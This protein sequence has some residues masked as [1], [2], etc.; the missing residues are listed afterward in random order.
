MSCNGL[1]DPGSLAEMNTF[2]LVWKMENEEASMDTVA[3]K[4]QMIINVTEFP[5]IPPEISHA[6]SVTGGSM[7]PLFVSAIGEASGD[8]AFFHDYLQGIHRRI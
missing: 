5:F 4:C 1:P 6:L 2:I 8:H 7:I 3:E